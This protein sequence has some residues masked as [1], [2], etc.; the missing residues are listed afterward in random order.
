MNALLMDAGNSRIKWALV[1]DGRL[2]PLQ[3]AEITDTG[4]LRD[5][6]ETAPEIGR[7]V[8]SSVAGPEVERML[9][10]VL[11]RA[12]APAAGVQATERA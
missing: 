1:R 11:R 10:N 8:A 3:A 9:G 12:G 4:A 6:L 2:E 7:V 5:W